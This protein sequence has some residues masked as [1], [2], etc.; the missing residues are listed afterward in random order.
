MVRSSM[1]EVLLAAGIRGHLN[2]FIARLPHALS[3]IL[4]NYVLAL[5]VLYKFLYRFEKA[6]LCFLF[7]SLILY[8]LLYYS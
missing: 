2:A 4:L 3:L 5:Y 6:F 7:Y 1:F 8:S